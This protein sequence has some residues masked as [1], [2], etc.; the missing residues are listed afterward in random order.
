MYDVI[1][2]DPPWTFRKGSSNSGNKWWGTAGNHYGLMSTAD[3]G[4]LPVGELGNL[5][6]ALFLWAAWPMLQ[7]AL[8]IISAWGYTYRTVAW[9]WLKTKNA[10][11]I[12]F[13]RPEDLSMGFGHYTRAVSEPC[14]LAVRGS[15][16]VAD[17]S[18]RAAILAPKSKHSKKPQEQYD[19]I[20]R[21]YP[22][23]KRLELFARDVF[24][25][26]HVWGDQA[27]PESM[28]PT[29]KRMLGEALGTYDV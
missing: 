26:W 20:G 3:I 23:T 5:N 18:V 4:Q 21:L 7:D 22:H 16:P 17:R 11:P 2:A 6:S 1:L 15:M 8:D 28:S 27:P 25:G 19:M 10:G 14:L 12:M 29:A 9:V 13:G 24:P